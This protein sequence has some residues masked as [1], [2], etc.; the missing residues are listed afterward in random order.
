[1]VNVQFPHLILKTLYANQSVRDRV[2]PFLKDDWFRENENISTIVSKIIDY[3]E[4]WGR[5]PSVIESRTMLRNDMGVLEEFDAAIA[6]PDEEAQSESILD[7]IQD[8]IR[9]DGAITEGPLTVRLVDLP[10]KSLE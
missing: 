5:F 10:K 2:T 6:I 3:M 9:K 7:D 4:K 8:F 1:M